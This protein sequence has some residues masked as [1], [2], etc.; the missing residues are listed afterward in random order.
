M[1]QKIFVVIL[2]VLLVTTGVVAAAEFHGSFGVD[3]GTGSVVIGP[4]SCE[5]DWSGS[6]WSECVDNSQTFVCFDKNY[7]G[8]ID[9][10]PT[11][12]GETQT[13]GD[14]SSS[15]SSS[16]SSSGSS[17]GSSS[18]SSSGGS[19]SSSSSGGLVPLSDTSSSGVCIERWKCEGWSNEEDSCGTRI[20]EDIN[21]CGTDRLAPEIARDCPEVGF[22]GITGS[23]IGAI[24]SPTGVSLIIILVIVGLFALVTI[25]QKK[26]ARAP[27]TPTS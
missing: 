24:S 16:S 12:C 22:S 17:G 7:C 23:V 18:S 9:L 1:E 13:C 8:T 11:L 21:E 4:S 3:V 19:S 27:P 5:E 14:P 20:C 2:A 10:R 25:A 15:S 6:L 26:G